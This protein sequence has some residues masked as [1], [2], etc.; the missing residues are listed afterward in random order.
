MC[1]RDSINFDDCSTLAIPGSELVIERATRPRPPEDPHSSGHVIID[2]FE[3]DHP[4]AHD[5]SKAPHEASGS[6][7]QP[8]AGALQSGENDADLDEQDAAHPYAGSR[9]ARRHKPRILPQTGLADASPLAS[10]FV[11]LGA[12]FGFAGAR[13]RRRED[14]RKDERR[15]H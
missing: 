13:R 6:E 10:M 2:P 11:A 12:L 5:E 15:N 8:E 9:L 14:K 1:I 7:Q 4:S 3:Y